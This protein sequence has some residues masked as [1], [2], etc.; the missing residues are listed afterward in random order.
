MRMI[1][2]DAPPN[3]QQ[4]VHLVG[5]HVLGH[6]Q[7]ND[8]FLGEERRLLKFL[9]FL[10]GD[11]RLRDFVGSIVIALYLRSLAWCIHD[12]YSLQWR[13]P[14]LLERFWS[15]N[16]SLKRIDALRWPT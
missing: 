16:D 6:S 9:P 7:I 14:L 3:V 11:R 5:Q 1:E 10:D 12:S 15:C 4:I 8:I 13:I 2:N